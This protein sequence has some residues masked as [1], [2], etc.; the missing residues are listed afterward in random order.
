MFEIRSIRRPLWRRANR[1]PFEQTLHPSFNVRQVITDAYLVTLASDEERNVSDI[2]ERVIIRYVLPPLHLSIEIFQICP[3]LL[4]RLFDFVIVRDIT[5]GALHAGVTVVDPD[6]DARPRE[7]VFGHQ[8]H[9]GILFFEVL[10]DNRGLVNNCITV[11]QH[12][13]F[14]VGI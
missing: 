2:G 11:D 13:N 3:K 9:L 6:S 5:G 1:G 7:R 10:I 4:P 8:R 12:R 14:A